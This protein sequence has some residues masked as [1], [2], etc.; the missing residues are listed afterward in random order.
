MNIQTVKNVSD[1]QP[2]YLPHSLYLKP[3]AKMV[4]SVQM[5]TAVTGKAISNWDVMENLRSMIVPDKFSVLKVSFT[6]FVQVAR[7]CLLMKN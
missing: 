6:S 2:L 5:P 1:C 7:V 3:H 4:I